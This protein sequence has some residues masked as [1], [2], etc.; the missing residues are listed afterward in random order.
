MM[1]QVTLDNYK[2]DKFYPKVVKAVDEILTDKDVV[3]TTEVFIKIGMLEKKKMDEWKAGRVP[4][5]EKVLS[6]SL[7]K[8]SRVL[9][10]LHF[11]VHDMNLVPQ[12]NVK[13]NGKTVLIYSKS[14]SPKL[15]KAYS[16]EYK[17]ISKS[18]NKN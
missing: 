18:R 5:L 10:I 4:Y 1:K 13:K 11:H 17:N 16:F 14:K 12:H 6:G 3:K 7:S 8:L 9:S 15:E 2:N